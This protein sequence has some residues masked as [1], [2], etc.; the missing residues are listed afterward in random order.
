MW[1]L[2]RMSSRWKLSPQYQLLEEKTAAFSI[3]QSC[4]W[5]IFL[6][7][8][9]VQGGSNFPGGKYHLEGGAGKEVCF[10]IYPLKSH[11]LRQLFHSSYPSD[12]LFSLERKDLQ[13]FQ[14]ASKAAIHLQQAKF[15]FKRV[16]DF[17]LAEIN[18]KSEQGANLIIQMCTWLALVPGL[19][20]WTWWKPC[21]GYAAVASQ[22]HWNHKNKILVLS[23]TKPSESQIKITDWEAIL[24]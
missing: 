15:C 1:W 3:A 20:S 8:Q 22:N 2:R 24:S 14:W 17:M 12:F 9:W 10:Y 13:P 7:L 18:W 19:L 5:R 11:S 21:S 23:V 4:L 6:I 16:K